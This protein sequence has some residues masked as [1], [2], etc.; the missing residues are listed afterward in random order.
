MIYWDVQTL[1]KMCGPGLQKKKMHSCIDTTAFPMS[2]NKSV[3]INLYV[4]TYS[5]LKCLYIT[6]IKFI[7][8]FNTVTNKNHICTFMWQNKLKLM[9]DYE[10][11]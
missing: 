5:K 6:Y 2:M 8:R 4:W 11:W 9:D 3:E 1:Q 10:I 7:Q